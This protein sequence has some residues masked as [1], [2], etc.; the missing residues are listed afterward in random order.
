MLP[1]HLSP[2]PETT[3][4]IIDAIKENPFVTRQKLVR[5]TGLTDDGVKYNLVKL[6]KDKT[7]KRIGGDKGGHWEVIQEKK[8]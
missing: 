1:P 8:K 4:K 3:Q 7:I 5:I 6:K 2:Y